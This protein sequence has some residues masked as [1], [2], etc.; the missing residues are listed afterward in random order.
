MLLGESHGRRVGVHAFLSRVLAAKQSNVSYPHIQ[1]STF[2][3]DRTEDGTSSLSLIAD[4]SANSPSVDR[5]AIW[6]RDMTCLPIVPA[7]LVGC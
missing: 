2:C 5:S 3:W 4:N 1:D 6:R 7:V